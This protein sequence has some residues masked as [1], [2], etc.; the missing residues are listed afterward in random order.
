MGN[1]PVGRH[2]PPFESGGSFTRSSRSSGE[3]IEVFPHGELDVK[4]E[5][6]RLMRACD[7]SSW[8]GLVT[9]GLRRYKNIHAHVGDKIENELVSPDY[10]RAPSTSPKRQPRGWYPG[11]IGTT[12]VWVDCWQWSSR[13]SEPIDFREASSLGWLEVSCL[14]WRYKDIGDYETR[15]VLEP[16]RVANP[17]YGAKHERLARLLGQQ[18][19]ERLE[20][21]QPTEES[22]RRRERLA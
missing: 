21:A 8:F 7:E 1:Q 10:W 9:S 11:A 14:T 6:A 13:S 5:L 15:L 19:K 20:A 18:I 16:E 3:W 17:I 12:W 22:R 2:Q 4:A